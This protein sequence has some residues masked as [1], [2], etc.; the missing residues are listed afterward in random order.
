MSVRVRFAPSPTGYLHIGGARTALFNWLFARREGGL[1]ILR[2]E[3]TDRERSSEAAVGAILD[4]MTWLGLDWD[5]GPLFQ[6]QRLAS[7]R[8][9]VEELKTKGRAYDC[10][11]T[12]EELEEM[13][14]RA[15]SEKRKPKYD[16]R[17]RERP[18]HPGR[19]AVVRFRSLDLGVTVVR[20]LLKGTVEFDNRELDDLVILRGDGMPT[21]NFGVV[22]DDHDLHISHVIRGDDHLNNT[23]R[24]MQMYEAL[25]WPM[26]QFAHV[27]MILGADKQ[28]LSKRHGATSVME[29][30]DQGILPWSLVNYLARLGWSAGDQ[31]IF[32]KEEL[33][34]AFSLEGIGSSA[35]VFGPDKLLWVNAHYLRQMSPEA[36]ATELAPF[37]S[38][39]VG[40]EVAGDPRLPKI[41]ALR[42]PRDKSLV[43][44]AKN[45]AY[46][47]AADESISYDPKARAKFLTPA[48]K[49]ILEK[50][51]ERLEALP[52]FDAASMEPVFTDLCA[53]LGEKML[54]LAQ[55]AR[56][57][58]T[59]G[60][61]SP[62]IHEVME[63]IGKASTVARL[64]RA[65][66]SVVV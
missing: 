5:E 39:E 6:T 45:S 54:N 56:V 36:L 62:G 30:R 15:L 27:P 21:Y 9:A 16:G 4:S 43:E 14:A 59:G 61:A 10:T 41:A 26:P 49:P 32:S 7:Y 37:V 29:Y 34:A 40:R 50:L 58:L 31:E 38:G 8:A 23:P 48:T 11:C 57:A 55:P 1:F 42:Q 64:R 28:R 66:A 22:V 24:Q 12:P 19:P 3:D 47:F 65:A 20:D 35:S 25:G 13:R 46:Y 52:A 33:I 51:A 53:E 44:M 17:C 2:I 63:L 60:T 18:S